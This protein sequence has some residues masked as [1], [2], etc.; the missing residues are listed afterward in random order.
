MC[1]AAVLLSGGSRPAPFLKPA[2]IGNEMRTPVSRF[3]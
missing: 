3:K 1:G 2:S